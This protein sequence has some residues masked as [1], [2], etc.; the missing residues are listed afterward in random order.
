MS[1]ESFR[2]KEL[3]RNVC[4]SDTFILLMGWVSDDT[5]LVVLRESRPREFGEG[6]RPKPGPTQG[7]VLKINVNSGKVETFVR[8]VGSA[9]HDHALSESRELLAI[10]EDDRP[11]RVTLLDVQTM[12]PLKQLPPVATDQW[13]G[14]IHWCDQDRSLAF[15][16]VGDA[17]YLYSMSTEEARRITQRKDTSMFLHGSVGRYV[18]L[19]QD[20]RQSRSRAKYFLHDVITEKRTVLPAGIN[21]RVFGIANNTRLVMQVGY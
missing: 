17:V 5:V 11:N 19:R 13:V 4:Q 12:K 3:M 14:S 15:W 20:P 9:C 18:V 7:R 1:L 6:L 10:A 2:E 8:P 21:G 16:N